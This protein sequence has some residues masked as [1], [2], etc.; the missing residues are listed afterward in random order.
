MTERLMDD[1]RTNDY[2]IDGNSLKPNPEYQKKILKI[3]SIG[4]LILII[5]IIIFFFMRNQNKLLNN[6]KNINRP[7]IDTKDYIFYELPNKMKVALISDN[8]TKISGCSLSVK[9]GSFYDIIIGLA[10]YSSKMILAGSEK[11]SNDTDTYIDKIKEMGGEYYI[12]TL[13]NMTTYSF[14]VHNDG[15]ILIL[16]IFA[17]ILDKPRLAFSK[18]FT[19]LEDYMSA[20]VDNANSQFLAS[21]NSK[22]L[23]KQVVKDFAEI[24]H[25]YHNFTL[26]NFD[27]LREK[28]KEND[29]KLK[30]YTYFLLSDVKS[31]FDTFYKTKDMTLVLYSNISIKDM[32]KKYF[33][34]FSFDSHSS[35]SSETFL[36]KE[37]FNQL[38]KGPYSNKNLNIFALYKSNNWNSVYF[39]FYFSNSNNLNIRIALE[40]FK[41]IFFSREQNTLIHSL[42]NKDIFEYTIDESDIGYS[43]FNIFSFRLHLHRNNKKENFLNVINDVYNYIDKIKG[44]INQELYNNLKDIYEFKFKTE[45]NTKDISKLTSGLSNRLFGE[46]YDNFLK[47]IVFPEFSEIIKKQIEEYLSQMKKENSIVVIATYE[48]LIF[49]E[50]NKNMT[51]KE[52]K[53]YN[54]I[55]YYKSGIEKFLNVN[56]LL[57]KN[58]NYEIRKINKNIPNISKNDLVKYTHSDYDLNDN[59]KTFRID[60]NKT[61]YYE[62]YFATERKLEIPKIEFVINFYSS[63][64][65]PCE[66]I[67]NTKLLPTITMPFIIEALLKQNFDEYFE[68][69][70]S[71][72][73]IRK[74]DYFYLKLILFNDKQK[75]SIKELLQKIINAIFTDSNE[76]IYLQRIG[77]ATIR[78][79]LIDYGQTGIDSISKLSF[80]IFKAMVA[81]LYIQPKELLNE[82]LKT[83]SFSSDYYK[84]F[85]KNVN[86]NVTI[87]GDVDK[88]KAKEYSDIIE[89][90]VI[91]KHEESEKKERIFRIA[92][93]SDNTVYYFYNKSDNPSEK[94]NVISIFYQIGKNSFKKY[95]YTELFN[96]CIGDIFINSLRKL[97]VTNVKTDLV[98]FNNI[99]YYQITS[100]LNKDSDIYKVDEEISKAINKSINEEIN[101]F[102]RFKEERDR[103]INDGKKI[104]RTNLYEVTEKIINKNEA[105]NDYNSE[106]NLIKNITKEDIT[107]YFSKKFRNFAKRICII[108]FHYQ[109]K[110]MEKEMEERMNIFRNKTHILNNNIT[111]IVT[112]N[113]LDTKIPRKK[114]YE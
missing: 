70:N 69:G 104:Y 94:Q 15:F 41:F 60:E 29:E 96:T 18:E 35:L 66:I 42:M 73:V 62:S 31:Y 59:C 111:N 86:L 112:S 33:D 65:Y 7:L 26:G 4:F 28:R 67:K 6:G 3:F 77:R 95:I 82:L 24:N 25:P 8:K 10:V 71:F 81:D 43:N 36:F 107:D 103:I 93:I 34:K 76:D 99:L 11:Y 21:N 5:S 44:N 16:D 80:E 52:L 13:N 64:Y 37:K 20:N 32:E 46:D 75:D 79:L 106:D 108:I 14:H 89:K 56:K 87:I 27:S 74:L 1:K 63:N 58:T 54:Y 109:E 100:Y 23:L 17:S 101:N 19:E 98:L 88:K 97:K 92:N 57:L 102:K 12:N 84:D 105:P 2:D 49:K 22:F 45:E 47:K 68:I 83:E 50:L 48:D 39:S 9:T 72:E 78:Q 40:Y 113:Y 90:K 30:N 55:Y 61:N 85:I 51:K 114:Y 91:E 53:Y 38:K 110:E